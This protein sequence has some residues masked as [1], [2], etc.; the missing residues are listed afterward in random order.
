M[1][2]YTRPAVCLTKISDCR[3]GTCVSRCCRE[4]TCPGVMGVGLCLNTKGSRG[5]EEPKHIIEG[6]K[7]KAEGVD[8]WPGDAGLSC[9]HEK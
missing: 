3:E 7:R 8:V 1:D 5:R 2:S 4:A 9:M 6:Y